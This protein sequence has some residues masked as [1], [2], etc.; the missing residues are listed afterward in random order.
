[1]T[2]LVTPVLCP[3]CILNIAKDM[4]VAE[5]GSV[6]AIKDG[7]PVSDGHLLIIPKRHTQDFFSMTE[8]ECRDAEAL[9]RLLK[10]QLEAEYEDITGFNVGVN[11]A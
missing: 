10:N 11:C 8:Q 1:M 4:I 6:F 2:S 3:F 9:I 7:F 5:H